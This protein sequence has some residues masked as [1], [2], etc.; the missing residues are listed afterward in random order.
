MRSNND[1]AGGDSAASVTGDY[2]PVVWRYLSEEENHA[3]RRGKNIPTRVLDEL[4]EA[5]RGKGE[6][7]TPAEYGAAFVGAFEV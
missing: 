3:R 6:G 4:L 1:A 7:M 5:W 2:P